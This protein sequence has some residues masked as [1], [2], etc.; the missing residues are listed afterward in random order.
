MNR[1]G[2]RSQ[3]TA[4]RALQVRDDITEPEAILGMSILRK[5]HIYFAFGEG[6]MYISP[7]SAPH[8]SQSTPEQGAPPQ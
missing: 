1:N 2:D 6:H 4:S 5:L 3:Q 7:A 8:P